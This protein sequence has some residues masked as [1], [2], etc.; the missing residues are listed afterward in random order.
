MVRDKI[1]SGVNVQRVNVWMEYGT[2]GCSVQDSFK[3]ERVE[4]TPHF[5]T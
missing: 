1:N 2:T 4:R 5:P 3:V